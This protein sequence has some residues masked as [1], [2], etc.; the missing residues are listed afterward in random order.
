M[1]IRRSAQVEDGFCALINPVGY[2]FALLG[3]IA[4]HQLTYSD[5]DDRSFDQK[6]CRELSYS[7][8]LRVHKP[9]VA[10]GTCCCLMYCYVGRCACAFSIP[11]KIFT[12]FAAWFKSVFAPKI[13][14]THALM[15]EQLVDAEH[16][17]AT[18]IV[19]VRILSRFSN[20]LTTI[21]ILHGMPL[22][23][24]ATIPTT[25][26]AVVVGAIKDSALETTSRRHSFGRRRKDPQCS[27]AW[28]TPVQQRAT[29]TSD[30]IRHIDGWL[31]QLEA[32]RGTRL[33][34]GSLDNGNS[35]HCGLYV[36][37]S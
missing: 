37:S 14:Q 26:D 1:A 22:A 12:R 25:W 17:G 24:Y 4:Q 19:P 3:P 30:I 35:Q 20:K 31:V 21:G 34:R 18:M 13:V 5:N 10:D 32:P 9:I 27:A 2:P 11:S 33:L 7:R 28:T 15:S 23:D 36:L 6:G 16:S 8:T 29:V